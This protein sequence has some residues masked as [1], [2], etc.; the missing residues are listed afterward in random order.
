MMR[1]TW[2]TLAALA[3]VLAVDAAA[4]SPAAFSRLGFGAQGVAM[5]NAVSADSSAS[6]WYNPALA[7]FATRQSLTAS[8]GNLSLDRDLQFVQLATPLQRAGIAVGLTHAEVS[9][10]DGRNNDGLHTQDYKTS[11][12]AGFL[13]FGLRFSK[14]VTAGIGLQ[15]F[16]SDL[17]DGLGA[18]N[19]VGIDLGVTALVRDDLRLALVLDDLLAR[20][21]WDSSSLFSSGGKTTTDNFPRRIRLGASHLQLDGRLQIVAE[22]E[23]R[24]SSAEIARSAVE[25][26][27]DSPVQ[28][29]RTEELTVRSD[30][31]RVGGKYTLTDYLSLS[32]GLDRT[33]GAAG[34]G[35][36]PATGFTLEQSIGALLTHVGYTWASEPYGMGNAHYISLR[37]YLEQ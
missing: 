31:F 8:I 19:T 33:A 21:S 18:V 35:F 30:L 20:F 25:L 14:R 27:G 23:A 4:Q 16:R 5:G 22:Y 29:R 6:P 26:L 24:F 12:F 17:I 10:I 3:V 15:L 7:P 28:T 1:R 36:R 13:A 11:E 34:G 2:T 32:A 37:L 9:G